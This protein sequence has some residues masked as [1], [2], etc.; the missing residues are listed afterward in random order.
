[1][2]AMLAVLLLVTY[3]CSQVLAGEA[4]R[5]AGPPSTYTLILENESVQVLRIRIAPSEKTPMHDVTPRVVLWLADAHFV[6]SFPDGTA[7]EEVRKAG[8][9]EW[10]PARRHAGQNIGKTPM[11]FIAVVLKSPSTPSRGN[12]TDH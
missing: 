9:V 7:H 12:V 2:K 5:P 1:M 3:M 11:E 6:D 8:A 4:D 10:V